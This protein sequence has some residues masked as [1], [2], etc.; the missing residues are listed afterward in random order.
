M[1]FTFYQITAF[2]FI[3][4]F[5]GWCVE[6]AYQG[7]TKGIL[8]N[9]GFLNGPVCPIYGVGM[10]GV[11]L[12][13]TPLADNLF[14][15]FVG[16]IIITTTIE[17]FGGWLLDKMFHMRW[18]DYSDKPFNL[19]GYICLEFCLIWGICVMSV[20]RLIHPMIEGFVNKV[21][22]T[23]GV[24]LLIIFVVVMI[25]DLIVTYKTVIGITRSLGEI[26]KIAETLHEI[27]ESL[28]KTVG[29]TAIV[30]TE[31][32]EASKEKMTGVVADGKEKV[33]EKKERVTEAMS[34]SKEILAAKRIELKEKQEDMEKKYVVLLEK[35]Q[36]QTRRFTKAFPQWRISNHKK[37]LAEY[38]KNLKK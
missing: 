31:K 7:V 2:F 6:V 3:Y 10:V 1:I 35:L 32:V 14:L 4:A 21:P 19:E 25:V 15:L 36:N 24:I 34:V 38:M 12:I 18:W 29:S 27:S 26:E 8:V 16:G 13:L 5:F 30:A 17:L 20:V 33:T 23:L 9:R 22:H 28:T 37:S 11:L